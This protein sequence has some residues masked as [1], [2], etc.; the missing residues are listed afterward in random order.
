MVISLNIISSKTLVKYLMSNNLGLIKETEEMQ[1]T[2]ELKEKIHHILL[3][4]KYPHK[5]DPMIELDQVARVLYWLQKNGVPCLGHLKHRI[6]L[7]CFRENSPLLPEFYRVVEAVKGELGS[8]LGY[9]RKRKQFLPQK[10][11]AAYAAAKSEYD[12]QNVL[13]PGVLV[14]PATST[15]PP[16]FVTTR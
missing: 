9:G 8:E 7:P 15:L 10:K 16:S 3:A 6:I 14:S 2:D 13:N 4:K 11:R 1:K 5:E 12:P